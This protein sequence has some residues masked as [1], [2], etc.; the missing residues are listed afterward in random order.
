M[1]GAN[2][3]SKLMSKERR[4][5]RRGKRQG[6]GKGRVK[7]EERKRQEKGKGRERKG[8]KNSVSHEPFLM[9]KVIVFVIILLAFVNPLERFT[10]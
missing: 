7:E 1:R 8:E 3:F 5:K 10:K 6:E 4:G 9:P 2:P